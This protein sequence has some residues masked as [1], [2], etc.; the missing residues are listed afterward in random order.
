MNFIFNFGRLTQKD[1]E[2]YIENMI[3]KPMEMFYLEDSKIEEKKMKKKEK[4]DNEEREEN[5]EEIEIENSMIKTKDIKDYLSD[6][7]YEQYKKLKN[8]AKDSLVQAQNNVRK[9]YGDSSVS[10]REIR[11]FSLFYEFFVHYLRKRRNLFKDMNYDEFENLE[12]NIYKDMKDFDLYKYAI[13]LSIF[14]CFYLRLT[15]KDYRKEFSSLMNKIFGFNFEEFPKKEEK[16]IVDN[17]EM[18]EGIAKNRAL[19][20]NIFA[21]FV[22]I[23]AKVPLFIVGKPGCSKSLSVQLLSKSM[24]G[25]ELSDNKLFNKLPKIMVS[26]YQGSLSSTSEGVKSVFERAR[27]SLENANKKNKN[28]I[29]M[30]FF[31]EMGLAEHSKNNPLKVIHSELEYDLN[32]GSKKIA[33]VGISNWVLD[34]SKMNRGI[35]L[36]ITQPDLQDLTDTAETIAKTYDDTL[37]NKNKSFFSNLAQTYFNYKEILAKHEKYQD[38]HGSRDFYHLIKNSTK[39]LLNKVKNTKNIEIDEQVKQTTGIDSLE[40]NFGGLELKNGDTSLELI[41]KEFKRKFE[42]VNIQKKYDVLKRIE[43][44]INDKD[45]RYLL[46]S[47]KSSVSYYL[48]KDILSS[49]NINKDSSFYIGSRFVKD[50]QSEEYILKILNKVQLQ[51]EQD[52]VLILTDLESVYPALYDLFNQNFT[53]MGTKNYARIAIGNSNNTLS[54]V[55]KNFRCLIL[56]DQNSIEEQQPPFLNRFEK[57]MISFEYLLPKKIAENVEK[58]YENIYQ[59]I[60]E[61]DDE[62]LKL[63]YN[64]KTLLVNCDKEEIQGIAYKKYNENKDISYDDLYEY[65]LEKVVP[66]LPQDLIL[67]MNFYKPKNTSWNQILKFYKRGVHSNLYNFLQTMDNPKNII[68]TFTNI[69]EPL[70][71]KNNNVIE[72]KMFGKINKDNIIDI[73]ISSLSSETN[74]ENELEKFYFEKDKRS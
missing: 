1:E 38:F 8:I 71:S 40:R 28:V 3:I 17:I 27:K 51:M 62:K 12:D 20:E 22:C 55:N 66:T 9:I 34:A 14:I 53:T 72:T 31:D 18:K 60:E 39:S 16:Y 68:Y 35:H 58:I 57:H 2:K 48:L 56:V 25:E 24:K 59:F 50:Q 11:R 70:F 47:S 13:N 63:S 74:L 54:F 73:L 4:E 7:L 10:L 29:S 61:P 32:E 45:S 52:K 65:V 21:L 69:D 46:L 19:L 23:N 33:F 44:N 5:K 42:N 49:K 6:E 36:S 67:F 26:S 15:N 41:K 30:F 43:E 37:A 64:L